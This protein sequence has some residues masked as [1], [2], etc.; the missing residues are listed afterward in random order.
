MPT[1]IKTAYPLPLRFTP[2]EKWEYC[3]VGY[4]AL[5]EIIRKVSGRPVERLSE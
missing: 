4:F 5:A 3:N 2:G 1:S